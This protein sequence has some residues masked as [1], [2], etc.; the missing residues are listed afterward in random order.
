MKLKQ[1]CSRRCMWNPPFLQIHKL[2]VSRKDN[3]FASLC[4]VLGQY[5]FNVCPPR[6]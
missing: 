5:T 3:L 1:K 4:C 6:V 2:Q